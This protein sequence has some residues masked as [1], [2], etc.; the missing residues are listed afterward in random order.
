MARQFQASRF[1]DAAGASRSRRREGRWLVHWCTYA[2][3][4]RDQAP[5]RIIETIRAK[6][7]AISALSPGP[8]RRKWSGEG[9]ISSSAEPEWRRPAA[10]ARPK[11]RAGPLFRS[12]PAEVSAYDAIPA[13]SHPAVSFPVQHA[14]CHVRSAML[15]S[16]RTDLD[17]PGRS[18]PHDWFKN[19]PA[20][21]ERFGAAVRPQSVAPV[22]A[23][24]PRARRRYCGRS[25]GGRRLRLNGRST[26]R[27]SA[28]AGC[29][30]TPSGR[31][32]GPQE[33]WRLSS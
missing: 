7:G 8:T 10:N 18:A 33:P 9:I 32:R 30:T 25:A 13:V 1:L 17:A 29:R 23:A 14:Y 19:G 20:A 12:T 21:R 31:R 4:W 5:G 26:S 28:G 27:Q 22:P 6:A 11:I 15:P 2:S 24:N 16:W 3:E